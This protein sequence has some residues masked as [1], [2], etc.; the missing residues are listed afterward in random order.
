MSLASIL[1]L[2][3]AVMGLYSNPAL[4][5]NSTLKAQ[6][7]TMATQVI[8]LATQALAQPPETQLGTAPTS[9]QPFSAVMPTSTA[10]TTAPIVINVVPPVQQAAPVQNI[11]QNAP[12]LGA[13]A[14]VKILP[15][16]SNTIIEHFTLSSTSISFYP[17]NGNIYDTL[18]VTVNCDNWNSPGTNAIM[19]SGTW[20]AIIT[21]D[22]TTPSSTYD[23]TSVSENNP[24]VISGLTPGMAYYYDFT[25]TKDGV[26]TTRKHTFSAKTSLK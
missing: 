16:I 2:L 22:C 14:P 21:S 26:S 17:G 9:S 7:D 5:G 18:F 23:I 8:A 6:V 11:V 13:V 3:M 19:S 4:V 12:V 1:V 24:A 20:P 10:S 15:L 25:A